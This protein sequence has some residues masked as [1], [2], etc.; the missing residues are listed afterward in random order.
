MNRASTDAVVAAVVG[1]SRGGDVA[2]E[3][4]NV[5][6]VMIGARCR[7]AKSEHPIPQ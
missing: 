7:H 4:G 5:V 6:L 1:R 3:V 2:N